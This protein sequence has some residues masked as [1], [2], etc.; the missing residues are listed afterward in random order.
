[1]N[2]SIIILG[3]LVL[4]GFYFS[5]RAAVGDNTDAQT[6]EYAARY[7]FLR[8]A[9]NYSVWVTDGNERYERDALDEVIDRYRGIVYKE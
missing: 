4:I 2:I 8:A 7:R 6:K 1:M 3:V 5:M 9:N